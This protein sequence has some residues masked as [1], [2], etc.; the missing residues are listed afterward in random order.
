MLNTPESILGSKRL[1]DLFCLGYNSNTW[2]NQLR[3]DAEIALSLKPMK[4]PVPSVEKAGSI[5]KVLFV[6]RKFDYFGDN[7]LCY[8]YKNFLRPLGELAQVKHFDPVENFRKHGRRAMNRMLLET[9]R[10]ED[11]DL[12]FFYVDIYLI[13][14][15]IGM[16]RFERSVLKELAE[17]SRSITFNW[18][19]DDE[20]TFASFAR[21]YAPRFNFCSTT[22]G[23][24]LR[25]HERLGYSNMLLS[26]WA[27]DERIYPKHDLKKDIDVS[28]VGQCIS[29]RKSIVRQ[30]EGRGIRV[31]CFGDG[32][33]QG[34][35]SHEEMV[36][37]FN[38]SKISLGLSKCARGT[39]THVK[40]RTFEVPACGTFFLVEDTPE[41][42]RYYSPGKEVA[43]F[44]NSDELAEKITYYLEHEKEREEIAQ[45]GYARTMKDHT[46]K[47]RF[48]EI[49][50]EIIRRGCQ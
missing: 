17:K 50:D 49:F 27:V 35:V 15:N 30:L 33:Q 34:H 24:A 1:F 13:F 12:I 6:S 2:F 22:Q 28:F 44:K 20:S 14:D 21:Y 37:I 5:R 3:V 10:R 42:G 39:L 8:H 48:K 38:R 16:S 25:K 11:P 23:A 4:A 19:G 18:F 47:A 36:K 31:K 32:W 40:S 7:E 46:Y 26:Q 41:L 45:A 29:D 9:V 43:V